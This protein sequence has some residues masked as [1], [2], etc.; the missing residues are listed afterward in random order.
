MDLKKNILHKNK[1][2]SVSN[3]DTDKENPIDSID[4]NKNHSKNDDK[5]NPDNTSQKNIDWSWLYKKEDWRAVWIG[6]SLFFLSLPTLGRI[7][8]LG[9]I[10]SAKPWTD[11]TQALSSKIFEPWLG[12]ILSFIFLALIMIP[13]T[14]YN[15]VKFKDWIK[16]FSIIFFSSWAIRI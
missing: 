8:L 7:Y 1:I 12:L 14:K 5:S 15:G 9:W 3:L 16:G 13:V 6:L 2:V 4:K 10:P 11:I